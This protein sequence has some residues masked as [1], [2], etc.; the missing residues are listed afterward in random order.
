MGNIKV[1]I[2]VE[3]DSH[4]TPCETKEQMQEQIECPFSYWDEENGCLSCT[5]TLRDCPMKTMKITN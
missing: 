5:Y 1:N 3:V 2:E 4:F